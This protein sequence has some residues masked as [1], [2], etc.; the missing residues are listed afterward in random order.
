MVKL[1]VVTLKSLSEKTIRL[2]QEMGVVHVK[3]ATELVPVDKATIERDMDRAKKAMN[4]IHEVIAYLNDEKTIFLPEHIIPL[5]LN[6]ITDHLNKIHDRFIKLTGETRRLEEKIASREE[7]GKY[8]GCLS[9]KI[10]V[11]LEDLHYSGTYLFARVLA[12]SR[13]AYSIF[14]EKAGQ[15]LLQGTAAPVED[16]VVV[17]FIAG[18]ENQRFIETLIRDIRAAILKIPD[19]GLTARE[20]LQKNDEMILKMKKAAEKSQKE[21]QNLIEKNLDQIVRFRELL[22]AECERM[23]VLKQASEAKYVTLIEGW[24]PEGNV[25]SATSRLKDEIANMFVDIDRPAPLDEPPTRLQNPAVIRPFQV[26]VN[27]F[28]LPRYGDWDP[29]PVVAYFFAFF[30]GLMLNDVVYAIG[31][32]LLARFLLDK[33]VDDPASEGVHLFRN[34]LYISGCA[35]LLFGLLSGT[36]LGD[37]LSR[38]FSIELKTIALAGQVQKQLSDPVSFII[39]SMLTGMLHVNTAHILALIRGIKEGNKGLILSKTGLFLSEISGI[40]YLFE[41]ML[42]IKLLPL[43]PEVY[44]FFVYPLSA[45]LIL[46]VTGALMQMGLPGLVFWVFDITGFLGDIMSY[47]RLAGVGLATF[48]LASS[49]NL[50]AEWSYS[51]VENMIPGTTGF[52]IASIAGTIILVVLHVFNLLLSSLAAFIHSLRLCFVEF[53]MKFYEGGGR[54]YAPFQLMYRRR[55][56][57]GTRP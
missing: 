7:L 23:S 55:I 20:F 45:G 35:A 4:H 9:G 19:E 46:I 47:S 34:V 49:F 16:E 43:G 48:Y 50:L 54:E 12:I 26:I 5:S 56:I 2:I 11:S 15:R 42:H 10:N 33:L 22:A 44:S 1:R 14:E 32:I 17:Y 29:T 39:L 36:F 25:E 41:A 40:P 38:G 8:M 37:F 53:L 18:V 13:E 57:V 51:A 28:G 30:F 3:E 24:V 21:T 31:L 27:L 52:V 6:E